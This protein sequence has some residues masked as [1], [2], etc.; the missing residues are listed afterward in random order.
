[1]SQWTT[2]DQA[3]YTFLKSNRCPACQMTDIDL[4]LP[5]CF[6]TYHSRCFRG[7]WCQPCQTY[8]HLS[9]ESQV[10]PSECRTCKGKTNLIACQT[11]QKRL[12]FACVSLNPLEGCCSTLKNDLF[13]YNCKCPGCEY[14]FSYSEMSFLSC[15]NHESLCKNCWSIGNMNGKCVLGCNISQNVNF[16][17][18]CQL[19]KKDGIRYYGVL[20][21]MNC[22]VCYS[23]QWKKI[24]SAKD[25]QQLVCAFCGNWLQYVCQAL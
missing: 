4:V 23:C 10:N 9:T 19:C 25:H 21:C 16:V 15:K 18:V 14:T 3:R 1:M 5:G 11:C 13:K 7:S 24:L 12:C 22:V 6:H 8:R 17:S 2:E 20:R